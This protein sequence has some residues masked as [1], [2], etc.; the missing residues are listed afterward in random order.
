MS[1]DILHITPSL[2]LGGAETFMY[3][4]IRRD[5]EFNHLILC[6]KG[7]G[8]Y[9][10]KLEEQGY[11]VFYLEFGSTFNLFKAYR[12]LKTIYANHNPAIINGWMYHGAIFGTFLSLFNDSM[13]LLWMIRHSNLNQESTK[14]LT[15]FIA[16][17]CSILSRK[18]PHFVVYNSMSAKE[19]HESVGY[20]KKKSLVIQNAFNKKKFYFSNTERSQIRQEFKITDTE[21]VLLHAARWH[22]DKD[23][24]TFFKA[25]D[26]LE[27]QFRNNLKIFLA[28]SDIDSNNNKLVSLLKKYK[29]FENVFLL[30]EVENMRRLYNA[31]DVT[32]LTSVTESFPNTLGESML[33]ATPCISSDVGDVRDLLG[34]FGW[35]FPVKNYLALSDLIYE[36]GSLKNKKEWKKIKMGCQK[37]IEH[38]YSW[39][40]VIKKYADLW[41]KEF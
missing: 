19:I 14:T 34:D 32:I 7:H 17:I 15:I 33:C 26:N 12:Q 4:L 16:K 27:G 41:S 36:I 9:G 40:V 13:K 21:L 25:L 37:K 18:F 31:A 2:G 39:D 23:H 11:H 24:E 35:I 1:K 8:Y 20:S 22:P 28:G 30:G 29:I 10:V 3:Q 5:N 38:N 6:L